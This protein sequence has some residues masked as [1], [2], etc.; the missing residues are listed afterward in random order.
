MSSPFGLHQELVAKQKPPDHQGRRFA[1]SPAE[2]FIQ[3][4]ISPHI[5]G[6]FRSRARHRGSPLLGCQ[7]RFGV[8][9]DVNSIVMRSQSACN[10]NCL[11][12]DEK[13]IAFLQLEAAIRI[14]NSEPSLRH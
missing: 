4:A 5:G 14:A 7:T 2:I 10:Q 3:R 1:T 13:L 8:I 12:A 11:R 6:N 9:P